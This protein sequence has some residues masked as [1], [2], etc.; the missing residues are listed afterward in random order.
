MNIKNSFLASE[1]PYK[2]LEKL[3]ISKRNF[4]DMPGEALDR[5]LTGRLSPMIKLSM[6]ADNQNYSLPAKIALARNTKG[7]VELRIFPRRKELMSNTGLSA[8]D[9]EKLKN[10][11]A[12]KKEMTEDG[13]KRGYYLQLD[14]ETNTLLRIKSDEVN[15]PNSIR[16]VVLGREQKEQLREGK[17]IELEVDGTKITAGINLDK[18]GGFSYVIGNMVEW[19]KQ[20]AIEWDRLTP[21][22]TGYWQTTENGWEYFNEANKSHGMSSEKPLENNINSEKSGWKR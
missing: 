21:G 13:K 1:I 9:V 15:I 10:G 3:G 5:I 4:L 16:N 18:I 12:I 7:D 17:P 22:A 8:K 20:K 14:K 6:S 11:N 19:E 2:E